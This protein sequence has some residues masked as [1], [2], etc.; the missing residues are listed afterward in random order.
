MEQGQIQPNTPVTLGSEIELAELSFGVDGREILKGLSFR[1]TAAR[2][3]I[4]GRNG[5]G[6]STLARLLAGLIAPVSGSVRING[7]DLARDRKAALT[8][9]GILFQNPDHQIIFPTV[10]EEV[11]FGLTQQGLAAD[12]AEATAQATLE[13]FGK[14]HW[15]EAGIAGL[16][17]GQKHLVC[18]MS[19]AAMAPRVLI[20]DE[21]FAGLDIPTKL[22]L[23]RYLE[24]YTGTLVHITHDPEDLRGYQSL[25][26]LDKGEI[27]QTGT[28][29]EVLTAYSDTMKH[30]GE[31][32]DIS[33]LSG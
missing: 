19:V 24:R 3:G 30:L 29:A 25:V 32:D 18:L 1:T 27:A 31:Q 15:A 14:S 21:P 7:K 16:S 5:S 10:L 28:D 4:V 2:V 33:D 26:W 22:Q 9:V 11:S 12:R 8:Q 20:L 13:S 17:Q 6:K 23:R